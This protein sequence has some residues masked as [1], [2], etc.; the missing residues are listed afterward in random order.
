MSNIRY[1][2]RPD[3]SEDGVFQVGLSPSNK[4]SFISFIESPLKALVI[5][6]IFV[7]LS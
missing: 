6:K 2:D 5:L 3:F 4:I 7:F 1:L